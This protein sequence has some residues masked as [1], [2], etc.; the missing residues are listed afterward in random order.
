MNSF[1]LIDKIFQT[2]A[3]S[4]A[5][6]VLPRTQLGR[7]RSVWLTPLLPCIWQLLE[8]GFILLRRIDTDR[9]KTGPEL[10]RCFLLLPWPTDV[11]ESL[12]IRFW[13]TIQCLN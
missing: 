4:R 9:F 12:R 7:R 13:T 10:L 5:S 11:A 8:T 6:V 1:R 2:F 3:I